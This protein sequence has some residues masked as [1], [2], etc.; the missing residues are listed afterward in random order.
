MDVRAFGKALWARGQCW[1]SQAQLSC[2]KDEGVSAGL[3]H[4]GVW[5]STTSSATVLEN[6]RRANLM[7]HAL[8]SDRNCPESGCRFS[9]YK[10]KSSNIYWI[11]LI[12]FFLGSLWQLQ[13]RILMPS[14]QMEKQTREGDRIW[15]HIS[16]PDIKVYLHSLS[17]ELQA[18][19]SQI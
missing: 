6:R 16:Q 13:M 10:K 7:P 17:L 5:G 8:P 9:V 3:E 15:G 2:A 11:D 1:G 4:V 18:D 14:P 12:V 19:E